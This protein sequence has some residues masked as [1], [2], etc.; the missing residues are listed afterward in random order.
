MRK[1]NKISQKE[2]GKL[3]NLSD[4]TISAYELSKISPDF[5]TIIKI[6]RICG[7]DFCVLDKNNN[8]VGVERFIKENE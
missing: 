8:I 6:F 4:T 2:L 5:E 1:Q 3:L 7:Y